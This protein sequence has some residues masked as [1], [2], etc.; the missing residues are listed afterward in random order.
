[1]RAVGLPLSA[2]VFA[3]SVVVH[4]LTFVPGVP[5]SMGATWPL[6]LGA[7]AAF[8]FLFFDTLRLRRDPA[9]REGE[10]LFAFWNRSHR[11]GQQAFW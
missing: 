7:M 1:M 4:V 5:V 2:A 8:A 10:G 9:R 11:E 3:L 6:H